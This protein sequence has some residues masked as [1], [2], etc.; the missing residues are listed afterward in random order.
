MDVIFD[1]MAVTGSD[2]VSFSHSG[3]KQELLEAL[4]ES[5]IQKISFDFNIMIISVIHYSN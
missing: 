3:M 4:L 5:Q 2:T 1:S